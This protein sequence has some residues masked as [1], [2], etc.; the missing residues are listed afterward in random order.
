MRKLHISKLDS[1]HLFNLSIEL[2]SIQTL[3]KTP[4]GDR[5]FIPMSGGTFSGDRLQGEIL[6]HGGTDLLLTRADGSNQQDAR[7]ALRTEDGELIL[8]TYRGIRN[9]AP[10]VNARMAAGEVVDASEYYLR[11]APFFETGAAKYAWLN[12]II[13]VGVGERTPSGVSYQVFEIL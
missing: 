13:A 11:I 10:E 5:K 4:A 6:P 8:M 12:N 9:S 7:L 2:H 3:G 1:R